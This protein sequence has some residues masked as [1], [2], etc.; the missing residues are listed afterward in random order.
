MAPASGHYFAAEPGTP[1]ERREIAL[2]L[3]DRSLR[4]TTDRQVFS[5]G[6][7]DPGTRYLLLDAP[8]PP[9]TG[10]FLDL[11]CGY[12]P[13]ACALAA[14][15]PGA[16]VWAVDVNQR[17]IELCRA[18]A[19]ANGLAN[20][21]V[22]PPDEVPAGTTFDLVWSN[23]PVRIGKA[24]MRDLLT[25]WLD[26]LRPTGSA[27]LVVQ[28]HLGADSLHRWLETEG[29]PVDRLGSR[30]GYRLLEIRPKAPR[31]PAGA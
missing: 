23:P 4:L 22:V 15:A 16:T 29:H 31:R 26:R 12:G 2:H 21:T 17:A 7:V 24:A 28:K 14:R 19:T 3:P 6:R 30:G 9:A 11:G 27:V 5:A 8:A 13:I 20:V 1:S 18:N 10:T 25:S